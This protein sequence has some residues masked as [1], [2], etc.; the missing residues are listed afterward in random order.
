MPLLLGHIHKE[1]IAGLMVLYGILEFLRQHFRS[2]KPARI[3]M[4][5]I[6]VHCVLIGEFLKRNALGSLLQ[7]DFFE[8]VDL[9]QG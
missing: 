5:G 1:D 8:A 7:N 3:A 6:A 9:R 4:G 2:E